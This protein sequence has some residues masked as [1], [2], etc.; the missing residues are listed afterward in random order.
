MLCMRFQ[1]ERKQN[2]SFSIMKPVKIELKDKRGGW[3]NNVTS[4][5]IDWNNNRVVAT[6]SKQHC[7]L[8]GGT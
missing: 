7:S 3:E 1:S 6:Q 5:K 2:L 4:K 8:T